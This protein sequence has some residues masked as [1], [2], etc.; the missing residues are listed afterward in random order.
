MQNT[1]ATADV[2][3]AAVAQAYED[4]IVDWVDRDTLELLLAADYGYN[5]EALARI[6]AADV[7]GLALQEDLVN[8]QQLEAARASA[9]DWAAANPN[10]EAW[11]ERPRATAHSQRPAAQATEVE[12]TE[13]EEEQEEH[14]RLAHRAA[15]LQQARRA[16]AAVNVPNAM[17]LYIVLMYEFGVS[18][19]FMESDSA[20]WREASQHG[21]VTGEQ[22]EQARLAGGSRFNYCGS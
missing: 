13:E 19:N 10:K 22:C 8:R 14:A 9:N 2:D 5:A 17:D 6:S 20:I 18:P 16:I 21:L 15:Q 3:R 4:L 7:W 11:D 1:T 12:R